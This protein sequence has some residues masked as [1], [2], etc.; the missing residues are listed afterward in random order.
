MTP[1]R[2]LV[3]GI[4]VLSIAMLFA[5]FNMIQILE[6]PTIWIAFLAALGTGV[7]KYALDK[8]KS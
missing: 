1:K 3:I 5:F 8:H 6:L 2:N 7:I 4:L